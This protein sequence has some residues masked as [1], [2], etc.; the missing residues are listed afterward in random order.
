MSNSFDMPKTYDF[1][2]AEQRLYAWWEA[3]GWFKPELETAEDPKTE[4][5]RTLANRLYDEEVFSVVVT[6]YFDNLHYNHIHVDLA[7]YRVDG[8]RP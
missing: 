6:P 8:S 1:A 4:F 2:A 7:R 5:L 3:Q